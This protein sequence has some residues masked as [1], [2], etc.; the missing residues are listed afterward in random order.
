[1]NGLRSGQLADAAGVNPQTL[2][3]YERIGLLAEPERT[4]G[5]HRMYPPEAVT[6]LRVVKAAQRLGFTLD[7]VA[8][9]LEA[10]RHRHGTTGPSGLRE[11]VAVKVADVETRIADL[12][13]IRDTLR[14]ALTAGCTDLIACSRTPSCPIPFSDL[15]E[16]KPADVPCCRP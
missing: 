4:P 6:V 8:D 7:E 15:A 9:L 13:V 2:R 3:Y 10:G 11:R 14:T 12:G 1:M 16:E 5:G